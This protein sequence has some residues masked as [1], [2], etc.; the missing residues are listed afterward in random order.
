METENKNINDDYNETS[1]WNSI[2]KQYNTLYQEAADL[3]I[4]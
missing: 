4:L 3:K 2:G 1:T